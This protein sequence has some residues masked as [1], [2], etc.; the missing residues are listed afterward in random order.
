MALSFLLG[1]A[2]AAILLQ[3]IRIA[4]NSWQHSRN[5]QKLGCGNVPSY[6]CKDPLGIDTLKQGL[7]ADK[8]KLIPELAEKRTKVISEQENRYVTTFS[9][10]NLGRT[11]ISTIDPKNV[12][13]ILATQF[14]DFELGVFRRYSLHPLLGTGVVSHMLKLVH[15]VSL[16][17]VVLMCSSS[18]PTER[19]GPDL[20][21]CFG[22]SLPA[23]KSVNWIWK[24]SMC[25]RLCKLCPLRPTDGP[26]QPT[27]RPSSSA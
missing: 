17:P 26:P 27:S 18:P 19:N 2:A 1:F 4:V 10:R 16:I 3:V 23:S 9:I 22:L 25:K 8:A 13:A 14:K 7:A 24:K 20:A 5:A 21:V 12:Q 15:C 11:H 6:P